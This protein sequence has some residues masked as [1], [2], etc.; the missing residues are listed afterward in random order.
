MRKYTVKLVIYGGPRYVGTIDVDGHFQRGQDGY[1][2]LGKEIRL[3]LKGLTVK[4][5]NF[6]TLTRQ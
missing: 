3:V 2:T 4:G 1:C 6:T 5:V